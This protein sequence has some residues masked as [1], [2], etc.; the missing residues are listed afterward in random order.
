MVLKTLQRILILA[1]FT[2]QSLALANGNPLHNQIQTLI[3]DVGE[4]GCY[5]VRSG[6]KHSSAEGVEHITRKYKHFRGDIDS[7]DGFIE[8]TST[9]SLF[10]GERYQVSCEGNSVDAAIWMQGRATRLGLL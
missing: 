4:S 10:T 9:K 7:I 3:D 2:W 5:F 8:L 1:L 6:K